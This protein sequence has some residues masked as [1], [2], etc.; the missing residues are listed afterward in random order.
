MAVATGSVDALVYG[1][2]IL[3]GIFCFGE[4]YPLASGWA[5]ATAGAS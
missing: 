1:A 2:G 3:A 4:A 5:H